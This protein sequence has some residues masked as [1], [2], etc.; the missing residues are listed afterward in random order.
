MTETPFPR[1][2]ERERF[3]PGAL[4]LVG[5]LLMV[6]G[7]LEAL[8][9]FRRVRQDVQRSGYA[10]AGLTFAMGL[11]VLGAPALAD[12]ALTL[13]LGLSFVID[14]IQRAVEL[15]Q[16]RDRRTTLTIALTVAGNVA[17][18]VLL[19]V[20][21]K[22]STIWIVAITGALRIF[23]VGWNMVMS[24]RPPGT[25]PP[26]CGAS[27]AGSSGPDPP[28]RAAGTEREGPTTV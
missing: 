25:P 23:G 24:P 1:A 13:L 14:A 11:L 2:V 8:H 28:R 6:A 26:R 9:C 17:M 7:L 22:G 10:S 20:L 27:A 15:R 12:T 18:A 16:R 5:I 19:L 3:G 4:R 21:W